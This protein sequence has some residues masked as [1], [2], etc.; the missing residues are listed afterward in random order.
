MFNLLNYANI[1]DVIKFAHSRCLSFLL[2]SLSIECD[3][4]RSLA[5]SSLHLFLSHLENSHAYFRNMVL[6]LINLLRNSLEKENQRIPSV[7]SVFLAETVMVIIEPGTTLYKPIVQFLLL[8]PAL[9]LTNV[10]EFYKLFNSSSLQYK[11]ERKWILNV[12]AHSCRTSLDYRIL[13]K[14]FVYRQL[15]SIYGSKLGEFDIKLS[16]LS[17]IHKT[18]K[19]KFALIDLIRKHYLLVWMSGAVQSSQLN[20]A[21]NELSLFCKLL[22]VF[23][24]IWLQLGNGASAEAAAPPVTFLNQMFALMKLLLNRLA[25][26]KEMDAN[27]HKSSQLAISNHAWQKVEMEC[28]F[29]VKHELCEAIKSL[30]FNLVQFEH[31]ESLSKR[32]KRV[33]EDGELKVEFCH[34]VDLIEFKKRKNSSSNDCSQNMKRFKNVLA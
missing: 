10:P 6:Y 18:C 21:D 26:L 33:L 5:Y 30:D 25:S 1:V 9:D 24:A 23:N 20:S 22:Q 15:M 11:T 3:R 4:L 8:K 29:K 34:I 19:C 7:I 12:L 2:A 27:E 14:R 32:L 17:L 31:E 16:I 28:F 13:E